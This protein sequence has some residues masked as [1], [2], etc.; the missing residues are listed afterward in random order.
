MARARTVSY[1]QIG[2]NSDQANID[3]LKRTGQRCPHEGRNVGIARLFHRIVVVCADEISF[4]FTHCAYPSMRRFADQAD[5]K[6]SSPVRT[7]STTTSVLPT[8]IDVSAREFDGNPDANQ[9]PAHLRKKRRAS[10]PARATRRI[11]RSP[12]LDRLPL[13]ESSIPPSYLPGTDRNPRP[14]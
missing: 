11:V 6:E 9:P 2:R 5:E 1:P 3:I 13:A 4:G 8:V 14:A 10:S 12:E 7:R